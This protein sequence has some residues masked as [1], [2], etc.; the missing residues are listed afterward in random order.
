MLS[1]CHGVLWRDT[2][3][4]NKRIAYSWFHE[5]E[6]GLRYTTVSESCN[7]RTNSGITQ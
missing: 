1:K 7:N 4:Y 6:S 5:Q 3:N 2:A